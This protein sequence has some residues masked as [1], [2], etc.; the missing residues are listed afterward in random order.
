MWFQKSVCLLL[1]RSCIWPEHRRERI[2]FL[3]L[4]SNGIKIAPN[5]DDAIFILEIYIYVKAGKSA[6]GE[7]LYAN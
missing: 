2:L 5:N 7:N 1:G 4:H 6:T 3:T